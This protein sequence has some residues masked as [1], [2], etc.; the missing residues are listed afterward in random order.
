MTDVLATAEKTTAEKHDTVTKIQSQTII[1]GARIA[2]MIFVVLGILHSVQLTI[3]S[4]GYYTGQAEAFIADATLSAIFPVIITL[5]RTIE[6]I[7]FIVLGIIIFLRRGDERMAML[8]G[9]FLVA[10][11]V[12]GI[13][14]PQYV[15]EPTTYID[16]NQLAAG[17]LTYGS[18]AWSSI[19]VFLYLFPDGRFVPRFNIIFLGLTFMLV[20][21]WSMPS[22][23]V[24]YP[25]KWPGILFAITHPPA[26]LIP[27][28]AQVYRYRN[29][30]TRIQRQQTKW[31]LFGILLTVI[32]MVIVTLLQVAFTERGSIAYDIITTILDFGYIFLPVSLAF[33]TLRSNLWDIDLIIN[34]SLAYAI[35]AIAGILVFFG[36]IAGVQ[37]V[38]G[39]TEPLVAL[40]IAAGF[41]AVVFQP[42]HRRAQK[43]VDRH[44][45]HFRFHVDE[46]RRANKTPEIKNAG[47]LSGQTLGEY[48]VLDVIGR[49]GMG[50]VYKA[51][52]GS[53]TVAIK[54]LHADKTDNAE[55][56]TRF[57]REATVGQTLNHPNIAPVHDIAEQDGLIY[58]IMDYLQGKDLSAWLRQN[59][60]VDM[61]MLQELLADL[62]SALD[63]AHAQGFVHRDIKPGNIMLIL[64]DD[65]ETYRAI[66]MDFGITKIKDANTL[67]G[68]GA[69][70]TI[71]YMAPEQIINAGEVDHRADIYALGILAYEMLLGERPFSGGAAQVMFAHIQQP[72]PDPRDINPD[73]PRSIAKAIMRALEK[74]PEDR[75]ESAQEMI[76]AM[77]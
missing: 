36:A 31:V 7:V 23:S 70:G 62:A 12:A 51:T 6:R 2:F 19:F 53:R 72:A 10:F 60:K 27:F 65:K 71:D 32:A 14:H 47:A 33:A 34:R 18:I 45:Y 69:I 35:V 49:G 26:F 54:T 64:N 3:A 58:L 5:M 11:G 55:I 4:M 67:T 13:G 77:R 57:R 56:V 17:W 75:F 76:E 41:S 68:T 59:E 52:D 40:L 48:Q 30:S 15:L 73:L 43:L 74:S 66:L 20:A 21:A 28:A 8:T 37:L 9:V 50:E 42:L 25:G 16:S 24:F 61:E 38:A 1:Q 29:V 63:Y 46:V 44:L 22:T 39:Q